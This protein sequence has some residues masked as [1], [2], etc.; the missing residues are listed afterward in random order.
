[1]RI[2]QVNTY[3]RKGGA[4]RIASSLYE[5]IDSA[6]Y[7]SRFIVGRRFGSDSNIYEINPDSAGGLWKK[8]FLKLAELSSYFPGADI[9]HYSNKICRH[10]AEPKKAYRWYKG[11]EEF[12]F[13]LS[14]QILE[15]PFGRSDLIHFHNLH[16]NYYDLRS[17][18][19]INNKIPILITL[20]DEWLLTGH[21][22]CSLDCRRWL[23]GCGNCPYLDTYPAINQDNTLNNWLTKKNIYS[24]C[25]FYV[26][27]PSN[28]LMQRVEKSILASSIIEGKII[29]NGVN[30]DIFKPSDKSQARKTVNIDNEAIV[31]VFIANYIRSN[32]FKDYKT[33]IKSVY[34]IGGYFP[35]K[36][37]ILL[38]IGEQGPVE[39]HDNIEI[40]FESY[41]ENQ[42]LIARY[43]QSAD[44]YLHAAYSEVWGLTIT[45]AQA[46]GI[47]VI[48]T[49]VG[50]ISEQICSLYRNDPVMKS[51]LP[52]D[53]ATGI[54]V[55]KE[56]VFQMTEAIKLLLSDNNLYK[57]ISDNAALK[58]K[59]NFNIDKMINNYIAW[60]R[61]ILK[62]E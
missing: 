1:M 58:A 50:G 17:L 39:Y 41:I 29:N 46:C 18:I 6:G 57:K 53:K 26:S 15:Y 52:V 45:E 27:T 31:F 8:A 13:P 14:R 59:R 2:L 20:H 3:D 56:N 33:V 38:A 36:K 16:G 61:E 22:A 5:G 60:Y 51:L 19:Q 21:C 44:L 42:K 55:E 25:R 35:D 62:I 48:A 23:S 34:N 11:Q 54:L 10:I 12:D 4:E 32:P 28:W 24:K 43:Y 30:T 37:V 49:S 9:K 47:P 40:R 7:N